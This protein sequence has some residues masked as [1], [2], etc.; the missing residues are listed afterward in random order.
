MADATKTP[1]W[2]LD[3]VRFTSDAGDDLTCREYFCA[4]LDRLW[5]EAE[6]FSGR[7]PFGNSGWDGD[8]LDALAEAGCI[9]RVGKYNYPDEKTGNAFVF[10]MIEAMKLPTPHAGGTDA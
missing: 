9:G 5:D 8:V 6:S 7:R 10:A 2:A 4:L 1:A 3:N